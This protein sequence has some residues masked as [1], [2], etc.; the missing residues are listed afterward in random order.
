[1]PRAH[2]SGAALR[3]EDPRAAH[4]KLY[5]LPYLTAP[6]TPSTEP[7]P[8]P[9]GLVLAEGGFDHLK[10]I[11]PYD[12]SLG[13]FNNVLQLALARG[14]EQDRRQRAAARVRLVRCRRMQHSAGTT[15]DAA[16][17]AVGFARDGNGAVRTPLLLNKPLR[18]SH[19]FKIFIWHIL[20]PLIFCLFFHLNPLSAKTIEKFC[21]IQP[22][23]NLFFLKLLL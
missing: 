20:T 18:Y 19:L 17:V 14:R 21:L 4:F 12:T 16:G 7:A 3:Y 9:A 8:N 10:G 11:W 13:A 22:A 1:M 23:G 6:H 5:H 2:Y 15:V